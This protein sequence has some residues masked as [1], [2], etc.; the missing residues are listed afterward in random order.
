MPRCIN[1]KAVLAPNFFLDENKIDGKSKCEFCVR[2][3]D[4]IRYGNMNEKSYSKL[5][6]IVD[7]DKFLKRISQ[8]ANIETMIEIEREKEK[9]FS[10]D[11]RIKV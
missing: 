8:A 7:Y 9:E 3:T 1:C 10:E 2:G 11:L 4:I 5:E 6:A